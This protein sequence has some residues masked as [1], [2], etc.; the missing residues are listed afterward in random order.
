MP[1]EAVT[2]YPVS[3]IIA[4][5][6]SPR[7]FSQ[8][9]V[10]VG[11]I[12]SILEAARWAASSSNQQPWRFIVARREEEAEWQKIFQCL[13]EGNQRWAVH[14]PVLMLSVAATIDRRGRT[15]RYAF[16]DIGLATAGMQA[17]A[18]SMGLYMHIMGGFYPEKVR[19]AFQISDAF[20]PCTA[21]ALG[22]LGDPAVLNEGDAASETAE[23]ERAPQSAFVFGGQ[24]GEPWTP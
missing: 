23:R 8:R 13:M 15:N 12:R 17:Q 19:E 20:E 9:S 11:E 4:D 5:R 22:G 10:S 16:H 18:T 24:W 6:W 21:I 1:K 7:A 14:A 3:R 2:E